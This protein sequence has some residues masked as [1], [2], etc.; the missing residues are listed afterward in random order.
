MD[1]E[2]QPLLDVREFLA[3]EDLAGWGPPEVTPLRTF[4]EA[5]LELE[6]TRYDLVILDVRAGGHEASAAALE[7]DD[8]GREVLRRIRE[9]RYVPVVFFTGIA[10]AV[11]DLEDR[12]VRVVSKPDGAGALVTQVRQLFDTGLPVVN[13]ALVRFIED[14]QRD[15]MWDFVDTSWDELRWRAIIRRSLTY[16]PAASAGRCLGH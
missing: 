1:D 10:G 9:Q 7:G 2:E 16:L 6:R 13:R 12:S 14:Q 11:Q 5:L 15:Y 4:D 3:D 8:A